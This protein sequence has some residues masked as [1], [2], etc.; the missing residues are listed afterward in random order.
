MFPW[1]KIT[2]Y[3]SLAI[4]CLFRTVCE[5]MPRREDDHKTCRRGSDT[6]DEYLW[7]IDSR[8]RVLGKETRAESHKRGI[9]H[10]V[11]HVVV[12]D[13][14]HR[15]FIKKRSKSKDMF[16]GQ[17]ETHVGGHVAFGDNT[18][19][20][21]ARELEEELGIVEKPV[22][23]RRFRYRGKEEENIT[24]FYVVTAKK[25]RLNRSEATRGEYITM[26][27]LEKALS[28]RTFVDGTQDELLIIK[29]L[30]S[31]LR[32]VSEEK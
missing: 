23:L 15:I 4:T 21:A 27:K 10:R 6:G 20:T 11:I 2:I 16:P 5:Y 3:E 14:R 9:I 29:K 24:F 12:L 31:E 7:A 19:Q 28:Q 13:P 32:R 25:L 18:R 17:W 8:G 22:Y 1:Q 30:W 26:Q